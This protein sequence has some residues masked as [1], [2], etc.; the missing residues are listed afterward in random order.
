MQDLIYV[1]KLSE[2]ILLSLFKLVIPTDFIFNEIIK[3]SI[4]LL[5][6]N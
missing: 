4:F 6:L 3:N 5:L 2:H 1:D